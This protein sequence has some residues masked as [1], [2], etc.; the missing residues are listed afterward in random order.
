MISEAN[1]VLEV[2][3]FA[4]GPLATNCYIVRETVSG[5]G[6]IIDPGA[7]DARV[8]EHIKAAG[9]DILNIVNTHGHADHIAGNAAFG[10]P[11]LIHALDAPCLSDPVRNLSMFSGED[12]SP[13]TAART[14]EDGD[15]IAVGGLELEVIHTPG[16]TPGGISLRCGDILFS[17]DTLFFEGAGRTDLPGGEAAEL[18]RS[19]RER[20]FT[21]PDHVK[22]YPGHG[23]ATTIGHE[24]LY[25][26]IY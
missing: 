25:G 21:L 18:A 3:V 19:I 10:F 5:K 26:S 22:V 15:R 2:A 20:L 9:V 14:L 16:H 12:C 6:V 23:P 11:V 24:K 1:N 8:G 13:V 17:G 4:V 7:Y